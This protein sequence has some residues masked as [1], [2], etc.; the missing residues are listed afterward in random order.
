[1]RLIDMKM[2]AFARLLTTDSM[3]DFQQC[4]KFLVQKAYRIDALAR[5]V[6]REKKNYDSAET[7]RRDG[8][9]GFLRRKNE[10]L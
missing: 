8:R 1:M 7:E 10:R 9:A 5:Y 4:Y 2:I 6:M 3:E